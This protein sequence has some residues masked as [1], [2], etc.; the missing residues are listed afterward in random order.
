MF[1]PENAFFRTLARLVDLVGLSLVW[2][3]VSLPVVTLA[4][5]TGA[6]YHAAV[7]E[8]RQGGGGAFRSFFRSF[9][10]NLRVGLPLS[11]V[12]ALF[13]LACYFGLGIMAT[14]AAARQGVAMV[15]YVAYCVVLLLPGGVLCWSFCLL[16]RYEMGPGAVLMTAFQLTLRHLPTSAAM[17]LLTALAV[18]L[19]LWYLPAVLLLPCLWAL[20]LS[21]PAERVLRRY[22]PGGGDEDPGSQD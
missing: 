16:S 10:G 12:A 17:A 15:L 4:P 5:A 19:C 22:T 8:I 2:L 7:R 13:L 3:L 14:M 1:N 18:Y 6:L 20:L 21:L 9:R 11:V